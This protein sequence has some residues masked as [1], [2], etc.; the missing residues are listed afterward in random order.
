MYKEGDIVEI[1][2]P[3]KRT[4]IG[5]IIHVSQHFKNA[6]GFIVFGFKGQVRNDV[7]SLFCT[8]HSESIKILGPLYTHMKAIEHYGWNS[9]SNKPIPD[10]VLMLTK[11][12]VGRG[13][14]VGDTYLGALEEFE[15]QIK[16]MLTMGMPVVYSEIESAFG[17]PEPT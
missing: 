2:L 16:P 15:D 9:I 12:E 5:W 13:V 1:P 17:K 8:D 3:D 14:Y 10:S 4:A 6:V 11:R 7:V